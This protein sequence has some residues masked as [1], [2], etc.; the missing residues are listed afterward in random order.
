MNESQEAMQ[1]ASK[2]EDY[3]KASRYK[4]KRDS[5]RLALIETLDKIENSLTSDHG[6]QDTST[7]N[8][9]DACRTHHKF[10]DISLST[11]RRVEE[12]DEPSVLTTATA[13]GPLFKTIDKPILENIGEQSRYSSNN[14]C[15]SSSIHEQFMSPLFYSPDQ[16][17][18]APTHP[19]EG[20]PDF[21]NLPTPEDINILE[22]RDEMGRSLSINNS[23]LTIDSMQKINAILGSYCTRCLFS[24]NWSLR[25]AALLKLSL[26]LQTRIIDNKTNYKSTADWWDGFSRGLIMILEKALN[27]RIV[28]V[29]LTGLL[30]LDDCIIQ[31][32][33]QCSS[34]KE[35][36]SLIGNLLIQLIDK[37]GDNNPKVVEGC[38][39]ALMSVAFSNTI[40]PMYVGSQVMKLMSL[41]DPKS[42]K[43]VA[44][45]CIFL[46]NLLEEFGNEAPSC[47]K[48]LEFIESF[49]LKHKDADA[50][51]AVKELAVALFLRD[52]QEVLTLMDGMPERV[53]KEYQVAFLHARQNMKPPISNQ[54]QIKNTLLASTGDV[55]DAAA[56][57][58]EIH[59]KMNDTYIVNTVPLDQAITATI[60]DIE[61]D[62]TK[63]A[64][65]RR[66][67]GRGRRGTQ[68]NSA[69]NL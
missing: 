9:F 27:D 57:E 40:G 45:R 59:A 44:K 25:E 56:T 33:E 1:A 10:D 23:H 26:E 4:A 55:D 16:D 29:F 66:G 52:G 14:S 5:A 17:K 12:E 39:T 22:G 69:F 53:A 30:L 6:S 38:E 54:M 46:Q 50:R 7:K 21:E 64:I 15:Y 62:I 18:H 24:K 65:G 63:K 41:S 19:L 20:V 36:L 11:I 2:N 35:V 60:R 3:L 34:Q 49:G 31:F 67:R 51:E 58:A 47:E 28:Q 32:E 37:L 8:K 42:M 43:S 48:F 13:S 68:H 61:H